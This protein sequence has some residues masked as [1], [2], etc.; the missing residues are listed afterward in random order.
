[1]G[2]DTSGCLLTQKILFPRSRNVGPDAQLL[3]YASSSQAG[4][5]A[6]QKQLLLAGSGEP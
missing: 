2:K 3:V 5:P 1:M 4:N 6:V